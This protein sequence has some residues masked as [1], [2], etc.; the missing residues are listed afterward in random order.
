MR[1]GAAWAHLSHTPSWLSA[2]LFVHTHS[3]FGLPSC[4]CVCPVISGAL[5]ERTHGTW[6][7]GHKKGGRGQGPTHARLA[8]IARSSCVG[9]IPSGGGS[10]A[11]PPDP[12]SRSSVPPRPKTSYAR[13]AARLPACPPVKLGVRFTAAGRAPLQW[14]AASV[15]AREGNLQCTCI[16]LL[17]SAL[18]IPSTDRPTDRPTC[19]PATLSTPNK[20]AVGPVAR[21][22]VCRRASTRPS[23]THLPNHGRVR[24]FPPPS[25]I[26]FLIAPARTES[27][28]L[29]GPGTDVAMYNEVMMGPS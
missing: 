1:P 20:Q 3:Y 13:L 21:R 8:G 25:P 10:H 24:R 12:S 17:H 4:A 14:W 22:V 26:T 2:C 28:S 23:V 27:S 18:P 9:G 11:S 5:A 15:A 6:R 7:P 19:P 16:T 29:R